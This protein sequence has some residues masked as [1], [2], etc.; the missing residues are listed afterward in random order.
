MAKI[1]KNFK[2]SDHEVKANEIF[3]GN[4]KFEKIVK[5]DREAFRSKISCSDMVTMYFDNC[6]AKARR[7]NDNLIVREDEID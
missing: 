7:F 6:E 2:I 3:K 1:N 4:K 5:Y